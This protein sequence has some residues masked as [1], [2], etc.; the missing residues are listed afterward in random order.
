MEFLDKGVKGM[1]TGD[2]SSFITRTVQS[3][4]EKDLKKL[5]TET[6]ALETLY[7]EHH[8]MNKMGSSQSAGT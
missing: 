2:L 4:L 6:E 3:V 1:L 7:A 5:R 8:F